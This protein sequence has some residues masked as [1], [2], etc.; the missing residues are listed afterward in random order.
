MCLFRKAV[1]RFVKV[2]TYPY[3]RDKALK[4]SSLESIRQGILKAFHH[5]GH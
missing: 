3:M 4:T 5:F 2:V 1:G